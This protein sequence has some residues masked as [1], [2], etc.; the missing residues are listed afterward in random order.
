MTSDT[1]PQTNRSN[2]PRPS[3][4]DDS[5]YDGA[6]HKMRGKSPPAHWLNF[7]DAG[8]VETLGGE[9]AL[10]TELEGCDF[11]SVASGLV[12]RSARYPR[13]ADSNLQWPDIGLLPVV[14]NALGSVRIED[15]TFVGLPNAIAGR[16]WLERFDSLSAG[17]W[18][19]S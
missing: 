5:A 3:K 9:G 16:G 4:Q 7:L 13:V 19:N 10:W 8:L 18:D 6:Q 14:A 2:L 11:R 15:P 12:I 17:T 1:V